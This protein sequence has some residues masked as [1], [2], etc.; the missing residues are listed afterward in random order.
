MTTGPAARAGRPFILLAGPCRQNFRAQIQSVPVPQ[1]KT[2]HEHTHTNA[3]GPPA[4][5]AAAPTFARP[6]FN[7]WT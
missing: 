3:V 6:P 7:E 5:M 2:P 1:C 4:K